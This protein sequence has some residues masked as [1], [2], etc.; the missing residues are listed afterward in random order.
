MPLDDHPA[1][2]AVRQWVRK[3]LTGLV[4]NDQ[5][6]DIVLVV[7]ELVTNAELHTRSPKALAMSHGHATVRVEVADGDPTPPVLQPPSTTRSGGRGICLVDAISTDWGVER[8]RNGK[9]IWS[10][11]EPR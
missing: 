4:P 7:V 1:M 5:L 8:Y 10:T 6:Q 3:R 9:S 11:F 2:T